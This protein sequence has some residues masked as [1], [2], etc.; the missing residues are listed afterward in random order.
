[1][2]VYHPD[3]K[4][5]IVRDAQLLREITPQTRLANGAISLADGLYESLD[6]AEFKRKDI[7]F[8]KDFSAKETKAHPVWQFV[9]RDETL[10]G[11]YVDVMLPEM[12][13]EFGYDEAM[14]LYLLS[15]PKEPQARAL[16]VSWLGGRSGLYGGDDLGSDNGHLVGVAPEARGKVD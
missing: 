12:K 7:L 16:C 14:G 5:K 15:T 4:F 6:R 13:R 10:L 9:A 3:G 8:D 1:M 11:N 2:I